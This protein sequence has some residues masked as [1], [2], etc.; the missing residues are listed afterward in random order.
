[1]GII[2]WLVDA[3]AIQSQKALLDSSYAPYART[4]QK[5]CWE[6]SFHIK[7]GYDIVVTMMNGTTEQKAMIQEALNRWWIPLVHFHGPPTDP[8]KDRDLYYRI[9]A[10]DNGTLRQ[11]F[12]S[13]YIPKIF[14]LGL[15]IP[16]PEL[17]FDTEANKWV[18]SDP[19][20]NELKMVVTGHGP[21]T[22]ARLNLRRDAYATTQWVRDVVLGKETVA[23]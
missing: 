14:E 22:E 20:W 13:K 1:V 4:M 2:A 10:K 8:A 11:E 18:Y 16:D 3:A 19:D 23:A 17:H 9:K 15:T 7:H 5:I 21:K 6:E 12:F